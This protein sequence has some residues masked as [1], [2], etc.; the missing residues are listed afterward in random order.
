LRL[1]G[2]F[3]L[4]VY[5]VEICLV[6][7]IKGFKVLVEVIFYYEVDFNVDLFLNFDLSD[8]LILVLN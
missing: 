5:V 2:S 3:F 6:D 1:E 4:C 8:L 7:D